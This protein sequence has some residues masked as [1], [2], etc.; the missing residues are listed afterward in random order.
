MS[1]RQVTLKDICGYVMLESYIFFL[2]TDSVDATVYSVVQHLQCL[3]KLYDQLASLE[4][5]AQLTHCFSAVA[6]LLACQCCS[7]RC[8]FVRVF[9]LYQ[10][11]D[12]SINCINIIQATV[13]V[14][15]SSVSGL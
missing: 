11:A 8:K 4:R 15:R 1:Q 9:L 10:H 2:L 7:C 5:H 13:H 12:I 3:V 14:H 6:V